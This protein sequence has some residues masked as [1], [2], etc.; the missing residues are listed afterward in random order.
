MHTFTRDWNLQAFANPATAAYKDNLSGLLLA[1]LHSLAA[2][3]STL[4]CA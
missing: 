4:A 2:S 3:P 1:L